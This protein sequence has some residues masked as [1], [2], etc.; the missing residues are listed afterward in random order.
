MH[1]P[2]WNGNEQ[3]KDISPRDPL[4]AL[5][6]GEELMRKRAP[7]DGLRVVLLNLLAGPDIGALDRHQD[8][9]LMEEDR[10]HDD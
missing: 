1:E 4:V 2:E 3:A 6:V 9:A 10:A 5:A 8:V 7:G